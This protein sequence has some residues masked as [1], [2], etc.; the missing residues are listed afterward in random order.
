MKKAR[1]YLNAGDFEE[2]DYH[3]SLALRT[4]DKAMYSS[5][6]IWRFSNVYAAP[7][8]LYLV[9]FL[10]AVL[11]FYMFQADNMVMSIDNIELNAFYAA[12]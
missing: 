12:T 8:W 3:I 5:S 9:G 10:I 2:S 4:Y 6:R 11:V 1:K 7:I